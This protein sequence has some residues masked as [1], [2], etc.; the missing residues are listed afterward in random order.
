MPIMIHKK[1]ENSNKIFKLNSIQM[2]SVNCTLRS[3]ILFTM[4]FSMFEDR[5]GKFQITSLIL[6]V[7]LFIWLTIFLVRLSI[8]LTIFF[9]S[10]LTRH[11]LLLD[12]YFK[13]HGLLH[14]QDSSSNLAYFSARILNLNQPNSQLKL[15]TRKNKTSR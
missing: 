10:F 7:R 2:I 9:I 11:N 14:G 13:L 6:L 5:C 12:R 4:R 3:S 1:V 15:V 8:R